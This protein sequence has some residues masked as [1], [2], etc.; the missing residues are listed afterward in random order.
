SLRLRLFVG[1]SA[2]ELNNLRWET[3]R[4][5]QTDQWLLTS[6]TVLFSR[7]L[8][9]MDWRPVH[10]RPR[11]S[12][13]ALVVIANPSD[14][15]RDQ[16]TAVDVAGELKRAGEGLG[17]IPMDP[18]P[19]GTRATLN[20]LCAALRDEY[21]ILY[22]VCHGAFVRGEPRLWLESETGEAEVVAG[23]DLVTRMNELE[24]R[25]RL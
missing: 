11:G 2:P 25:P 6:E 4:D 16:L 8:S 3:L 14:L 21:D 9:S 22:L 7:Y 13:R 19:A 18:L 5:P 17:T 12:L 15:A 24:H 23:D 20:N 1:P 10:L